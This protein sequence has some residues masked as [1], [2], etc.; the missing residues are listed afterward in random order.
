ML[1]SLQTPRRSRRKTERAQTRARSFVD[2]VQALPAQAL[3]VPRA[4][5]SG[6]VAAAQ[7]LTTEALETGLLEYAA[8]LR[9]R[10]K[11]EKMQH[12]L[13]NE[14]KQVSPRARIVRAHSSQLRCAHAC[15]AILR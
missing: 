14:Q 11:D 4:P 12:L 2:Q 10:A 1:F 7:V 6:G 13:P 9:E 8:V 3:S 15:L 5:P